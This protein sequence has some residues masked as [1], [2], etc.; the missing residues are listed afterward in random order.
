MMKM[1]VKS[2]IPRPN[3]SSSMQL[4][5]KSAQFVF[6]SHV[7]VVEERSS[8]T[9]FVS[10]FVERFAEDDRTMVASDRGI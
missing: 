2:P 1:S 9:E 5:F 6:A 10:E 4:I 3:L 8:S 7:C